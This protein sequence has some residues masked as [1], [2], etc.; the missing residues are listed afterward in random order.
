[1]EENIDT[2]GAFIPIIAGLVLVWFVWA[3]VEAV[4]RTLGQTKQ[5]VRDRLKKE[6]LGSLGERFWC[7]SFVVLIRFYYSRYCM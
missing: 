5:P 1:M 2:K 7:A 3:G 6:D 4:S